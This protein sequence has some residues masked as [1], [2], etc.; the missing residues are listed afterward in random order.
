[1]VLVQSVLDYGFGIEQVND[2]VNLLGQCIANGHNVKVLSHLEQEMLRVR[3]E[4]KS[5]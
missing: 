5:F 1:M 4:Y 3:S 2:L